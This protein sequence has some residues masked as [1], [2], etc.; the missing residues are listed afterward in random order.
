MFFAKTERQG[1]EKQD[2][3]DDGAMSELKKCSVKAVR[4]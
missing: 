1:A 3:T 4:K 2:E